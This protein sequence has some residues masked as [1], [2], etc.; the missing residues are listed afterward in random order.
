VKKIIFLMVCVVALALVSM[1]G[2]ADFVQRYTERLATNKYVQSVFMI[3]MQMLEHRSDRFNE[4]VIRK[5]D[6]MIAD[7]ERTGTN[8]SFK[9]EVK[10]MSVS[11]QGPTESAE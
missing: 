10:I 9:H 2:S 3:E 8:A 5:T 7:A 1:D 4:Q 11:A 6:A